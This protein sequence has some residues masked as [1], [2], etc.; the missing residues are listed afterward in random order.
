MKYRLL[1][2]AFLFMSLTTLAQERQIHSV[3]NWGELPAIP[4]KHGFAGSF[5]GT[6]HGALIVAGGANF[7]DGGAPWTG[8]KKVW[9]NKIYVLDKPTGT[10]KVAGELPHPMGYGV[11]ISYHNKMICIGGSNAAGHL[12]TVY[13]ISYMNDKIKIEKWPDLPQ[14]LANACGTWVGHTVYIA[15]GLFHPD[16]K[17]TANIFWSFNLSAPKTSTW[18]KLETWPGP[19]RMLAAA[20]QTTN[21][22]YLFSGTDLED[23][24]GT[25]HRRY[26][27]DAYKYTIGKGWEKLPDMPAATVAAPSHVVFLNKNKLLIFGGDDGKLTDAAANLKERH[28]G[29]SDHVLVYHLEKN[30]WIDELRI[31]TDKKPDAAANPNGSIWAPVTTTSVTWHGMI[32]FPGGESRPAV[33]TPRVLTATIKQGEWIKD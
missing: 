3:L 31:K 15:G 20:G 23:K 28:P 29:F 26:L 6:S 19:P 2:I 21:A 30:K 22:F 7:P 10:W 16:D 14:P 9:T 8:S 4:D 18:Q 12:A 17:S 1:Y 25:A 11:S 27:T 33:R 5:A 32:V 13:A 24:N